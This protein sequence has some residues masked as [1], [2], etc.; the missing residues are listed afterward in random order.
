MGCTNSKEVQSGSPKYPS[1][2]G[3]GGQE[4]NRRDNED[5]GGHK[6][7]PTKH[8][9]APKR[10]SMVLTGVEDRVDSC[11]F[12][13]DANLGAATVRYAYLSQRGY[14]PD[15]E[16]KANQDAYDIT[17]NFCSSSRTDAEAN[18]DA[19]LAVFDG[20]GR[21]GD[22]CAQFAKRHLANIIEKAVAEA[23]KKKGATITQNGSIRNLQ[24]GAFKHDSNLALLTKEEYQQICVKAHL[25]TN[26]MMHQAKGFDDSLSGTT[27]ISVTFH[28]SGGGDPEITVCNVGDSRAIMGQQLENSKALKAIPL[29]LDQTPY[30]RDERRRIKKT[31]ARI[32]SLDQIEGLEPLVESDDEEEDLQLG[33]TIDEGGDPP[34]VWAPNGEYPGTAFTRSLGDMIAEELG[35]VAEPEMVTRPLTK[36]DKIIVIASDGVFEFLTNQ[37]VIDICAKFDDPLEACRA[38]VAE[39]YELWLQY[40]LRTDDITMICIFIDDLIETKAPL[41]WSMSKKSLVENVSRASIASS[42]HGSVSDLGYSLP[43]EAQKPVRTEMSKKK[44][45]ELEKR[46]AKSIR[47]INYDDDFDINDLVTEKSNDD[48]ARIAEAIKASVIFKDINEQQ[49]E[50][51][52]GVMEQISVKAGDWVIKQG[53]M[54]DKFYIV[55]QG[56]FEVRIV[57]QG[58]EDD[59]TGG[60]LVHV[61]A[62]SKTSNAHP[63]FGELALMYSAPRAASIIAQTDGQLWALHRA[64]FNKILAEHNIR[65][66]IRHKLRKLRAFRGLT[67]DELQLIVD[68]ME[69]TVY[70]PGETLVKE[71]E[72]GDT[73][74]FIISGSAEQSSEG[75]TKNI[76]E[77]E[78]FGESMLLKKG[79]YGFTVKASS[80]TKCLKLHLSSIEE[81]VGS[82]VGR[83]AHA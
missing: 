80:E 3:P 71:G 33:E 45:M 6:G 15:D 9:Q 67:T 23:C 10:A 78:H 43:M 53:E 41:P 69:E 73:F 37:S 21:Y 25:Q 72:Q 46:K 36:S 74:F 32:M 24:E 49:R 18:E 82:L 7:A 29:S 59:G 8:H 68:S 2:D 77:N 30:R 44:A 19:F 75:T 64:V 1:G 42:A 50:L 57:P 56:K 13:I 39:S 81:K 35:V 51:I 52:Y 70:K 47:Q 58:G 31:G 54:G 28:G 26:K 79:P 61:Y 20:H 34:R 17:E 4:Q 66:E 12:A 14:Y 60:T 55:E 48:K 62:G 65:R 38:V 22:S 76:K 63:S 27:A 5:P 83:S 16:N 40:E 11:H